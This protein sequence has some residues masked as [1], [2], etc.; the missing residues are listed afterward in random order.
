MS[1]YEELKRR[2]VFRVAIAYSIIAWVL[3]QVSDLAFDNFGT[4]DWVAKTFLF[5][6]VVGLPLAV[7]F[8]WAFELTPEGIKKEK[9]VDRTASITPQT[10]KKLN[11]VIICVLVVAVG[12]LLSKQF[13][14]IDEEAPF[15]VTQTDTSK[16]SIAILP[17]ENR[18][19]RE[20]DEFFAE[21]IHDDLLTTIANIGSMKVISRTSV[22]KYK[23]SAKQI[24]EIAEELGVANILEGGIQ[25]SGSQVR[26][27]VQL[28]DAETDEH[29][30]AEIYDRQLTAENLFVIQ[31]EVSNAIAQALHTTLSPEEQQRVSAIP[32][33]NL[34]AYEAYML[35]R[36]HWNLR[37][38]N[39]LAEA[40]M[41]FQEAI[42]LDPNYARAY[43]G[44][45]D[46]LRLQVPYGGVPRAEAF[47]RAEIAARKAL[48]LDD[49]LGEAYATLGGLMRQMGDNDAGEAELRRAIE[50]NPNYAPAYNWLGL[51]L[52]D[53]GEFETAQEIFSKGLEIDPLSPVLNTNRT[54]NLGLQG[55]FDEMKA[56]AERHIEI[57]PDSMFGYTEVSTYEYTV[58]GRLDTALVWIIKASDMDPNNINL[59]VAVASNFLDLGDY[60]SAE[61]WTERAAE[62]RAENV[63]VSNARFELALFK[64]D[65]EEVLRHAKET[66]ELAGN[67]LFDSRILSVLMRDDLN[68]DRGADALARYERMFPELFAEAYELNLSNYYIVPNVAYLLRETGSRDRA[69]R[70]L[71]DAIL[72]MDSIGPLGPSGHGPF[73]AVALTLSGDNAGALLELGEAADAGWRYSTWYFFDDHPVLKALQ[74]EPEFQRIRTKV[75]EDMAKQL[76][77]V[78]RMEANGELPTNW[79][80]PAAKSAPPPT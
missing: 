45:S 12:F 63:S 61:S 58:T 1:L 25:R 78:R 39:S 48:E 38:A 4:P 55:R 35:G 65:A 41:L 8:A 74:N 57:N 71:K 40:A 26:I 76:E 34:E 33:L 43:A 53:R 20:E 69:D 75:A 21:G 80:R 15:E 52:N 24:P 30:W 62:I 37:T 54:Y 70:M 68:N 7:F 18:S 16:L 46:A 50:L 28:I 3:A 77:N 32:T 6:L 9:D 72:I 10:G 31:S 79:A 19:N 11:Y 44:L 49:Q 29:L 73:K 36:Q 60:Q 2:N 66:S 27:N 14:T 23:D 47:P 42:D 22:M 13:E 67:S 56:A 64:G 59:L 17:F 5:L 51:S